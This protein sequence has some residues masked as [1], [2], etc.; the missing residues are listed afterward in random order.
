MSIRK[1]SGSSLWDARA[2]TSPWRLWSV[3]VGCLRRTTFTPVSCSKRPI[4]VSQKSSSEGVPPTE[5]VIV[6]SGFRVQAVKATT[7]HRTAVRRKRYFGIGLKGGI[8]P[9]PIK[10]IAGI[11]LKTY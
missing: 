6:V 5:K 8:Q 3:A 1:T 2:T 9:I 10:G 11:L 4:R 7:V